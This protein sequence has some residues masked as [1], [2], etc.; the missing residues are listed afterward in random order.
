MPS[1]LLNYKVVPVLVTRHNCIASTLCIMSHVL[2]RATA[3]SRQLLSDSGTA[4]AEASVS[5]NFGKQD[6]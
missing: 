4:V 6:V 1:T 3:S 2:A 5:P